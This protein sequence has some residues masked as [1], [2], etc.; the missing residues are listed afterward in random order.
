MTDPHSINP[1]TP[2]PTPQQQD[3]K[4]PQAPESAREKGL[5]GHDVE[6]IGSMITSDP[7]STNMGESSED[8][9]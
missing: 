2:A 9:P 1:G 5:D 7:P 6:V 3:E 4:L 8:L